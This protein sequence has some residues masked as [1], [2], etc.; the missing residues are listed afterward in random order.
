MGM[1]SL[2]AMFHLFHSTITCIN[3]K[4][5]KYETEATAQVS[6]NFRQPGNERHVARLRPRDLDT[7]RRTPPRPARE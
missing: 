7:A 3:L 5:K 1:S 6:G 4:D 2:W